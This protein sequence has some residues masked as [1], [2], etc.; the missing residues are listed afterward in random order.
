M[1]RPS[2]KRCAEQRDL[3]RKFKVAGVDDY[4]EE[5]RI[6]GD[7]IFKRVNEI[8]LR[9]MD[10][11]SKVEKP[12]MPEDRRRAKIERVFNEYFEFLKEMGEEEKGFKS[13]NK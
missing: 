5:H 13:Q 3:H 10:G 12:P 8:R 1:E 4:V 11:Q 7:D 2:G 9:Y 6:V